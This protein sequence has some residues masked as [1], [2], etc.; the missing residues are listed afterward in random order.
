MTDSAPS[1]PPI[2]PILLP[3]SIVDQLTREDSPDIVTLSPNLTEPIIA[4]LVEGSPYAE[5]LWKT[6][7]AIIK[8]LE[9]GAPGW[10][11]WPSNSK[12]VLAV[13]IMLGFWIENQA[14]LLIEE[15]SEEE[16]APIEEACRE[17]GK[18]L[19]QYLIDRIVEGK[20]DEEY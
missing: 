12:D 2:V 5:A 4:R 16:L 13:G 20:E 14:N 15:A 18:S 3:P 8:H 9:S 7:T 11:P 19:E 10:G 17:Q 1:D 6:R